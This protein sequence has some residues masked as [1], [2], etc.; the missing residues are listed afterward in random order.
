MLAGVLGREPLDQPL[1]L[2]QCW[3]S[4]LLVHQPKIENRNC[5]GDNNL[6]ASLPGTTL[7]HVVCL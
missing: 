5:Q 7:M 6:E 2:L 4:H 1:P 3:K